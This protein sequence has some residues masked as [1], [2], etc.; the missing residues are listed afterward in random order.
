MKNDIPE[1]D[2]LLDGIN[3]P[4]VVLPPKTP[5]AGADVIEE[6]ITPGNT[7]PAV[8]TV[9]ENSERCWNNFLSHISDTNSKPEKE[10]RLVCK[11]DR[12]LADSLDDCDIGNRCR[13]DI[14]N[15][16]VRAFFSTYL[17]KLVKY[18]REKKSLFKNF[19][20][21]RNETDTMD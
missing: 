9:P 8:S 10:D 11:I 2:T 6:P 16:I 3:D 5:E 20:I 19:N 18:R 7:A 17:S 1:I 14:V 21:R 12:D 15:A 13:S 4:D